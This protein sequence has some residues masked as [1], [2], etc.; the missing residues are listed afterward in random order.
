MA[1]AARLAAFWSEF[2][3]AFQNATASEKILPAA[4]RMRRFGSDANP[5]LA[6]QWRVMCRRAFNDRER[7][8][9]C[10][11]DFIRFAEGHREDLRLLSELQLDIMRR[12]L[13]DDFALRRSA[14]VLLGSGTLSSEGR[15]DQHVMQGVRPMSAKAQYTIWFA[16]A[17]AASSLVEP[18]WTQIAAFIGMACNCHLMLRPEEYGNTRT[19]DAA[20][21]ALLFDRWQVADGARDI[22]QAR[23]DAQLWELV[24]T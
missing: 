7:H 8:D 19:P 2:D 14:F 18:R 9:V 4:A 12:H 21:T 23:L 11:A 16:F 5:H 1:D 3:A 10:F 15:T 24:Q 6:S 22:D 17:R 20:Q 13:G